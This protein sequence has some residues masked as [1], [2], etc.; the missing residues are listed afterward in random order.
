MLFGLLL[1]YEYAHWLTFFASYIPQH[2]SLIC[3][4]QVW[5][6]PDELSHLHVFHVFWMNS[7]ACFLPSY[8]PAFLILLSFS[9]ICMCMDWPS[10]AQHFGSRFW[11]EWPSSVRAVSLI[12]VFFHI[13]WMNRP[14]LIRSGTCEAWPLNWPNEQR[15]L[16]FDALECPWR[17]V[18]L[19]GRNDLLT[20][21]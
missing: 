9:L 21:C 13:F 18:P 4:W 6:W 19:F 15:F 20:A 16:L 11:F 14:S 17:R 3:V 8:L 2:D 10:I 1:S 12:C 5:P 7:P